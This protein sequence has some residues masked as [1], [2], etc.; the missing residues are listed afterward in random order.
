MERHARTTPADPEP[1][2]QARLAALFEDG[3]E[4][5]HHFD[6]EVR[7][8]EWHPFVHGDYERVLRALLAERAPGRRFLEWG[9]ATGVVTIMADLLGFE[10]CGIELDGDLVRV[11]RDLARRHGSGARFAEGSFLPMGYRWRS[12]ADDARLGTIGEGPSGYLELGHHLDEFDVVYGYPWPG[13]D[14]LMVDL[15][16]RYGGREATL[17]LYHGGDEVEVLGAGGRDLLRGRS[18]RSGGRPRAS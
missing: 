11:A 5:W 8:R 9:S 12:G 16:R 15:M 7:G 3:W 18:Q 1:A 17:L 10:A 6:A 4:I 13:E 2:L 14:G